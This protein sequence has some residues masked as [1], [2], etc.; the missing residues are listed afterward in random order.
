MGFLIDAAVR[1]TVVL[2]L[3]WLAAA[4]LHRSS[5]DVRGRIWR[6][7]LAATALL[8]IPVPLPEA[9]RISSTALA[10]VAG[11]STGVTGSVPLLQT[12]WIA[13]FVLLLAQLA[14]R[15]AALIRLTRLA[16]PFQEPGVLMSGSIVTP[17]TWGA[18]HPVILLP[19]YALDCKASTYQAMIRHERAHIERQDWLWQILAQCVTAAFW[20][21]PLAWLASA[22]L[23]S[24]AEHAA[25]D[26]VLA[27]GR[28]PSSYAR[29]LL[30]IVRRVN[31]TAPQAAIAMIRRPGALESRIA[32]ILDSS[33]TRSSAAFRTRVTVVSTAACL[34]LFLAACQSARL[35][36]VAQVQT[37]PKVV[38]KVEPGYTEDARSSKI[39]GT[40]VVS[41][42]VDAQ[43]RAKN[44][45]VTKPLDQ[46]LDQQAL[47]AIEKW[48]FAPGMKDG[49]PVRVAATIEVNF[50][51]R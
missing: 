9:V 29:Q 47:A 19:T 37:P 43:G 25:D 1:A 46:G 10:D 34:L 28:E 41:L 7:A 17:I 24:E 40:V 33:R 42:E 20:F 4:L 22:R 23:R 49:K 15:L 36:R 21:H 32:A 5:A 11:V 12:I 51:L 45:R 26:R 14:F 6:A 44:I 50:H 30:D 8:L 13:G 38:S 39:E 16:S 3:A 27:D 31:R 48:R 35:Y 18:H 2:G